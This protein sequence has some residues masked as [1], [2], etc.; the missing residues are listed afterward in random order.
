MHR[1]GV[2]AAIN[3]D[4]R[5]FLCI[6][7]YSSISRVTSVF[8]RAGMIS[9]DIGTRNEMLYRVRSGTV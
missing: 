6:E 4:R 2:A 1:V 3:N 9:A 5:L 7:H 8:R